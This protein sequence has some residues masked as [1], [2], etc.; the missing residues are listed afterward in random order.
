MIYR[1]T[2]TLKDGRECLLRNGTGDDARAVLDIFTLTHGQTDFLASYPDEVS[3]TL[4][5]EQDFLVGKEKSERDV[6]IVA[7]IDG[8]IV[9]S[10]GNIG[11]GKSEKTKHRASFGISVDK[12]YWGIGIGRAMT[13]ACIE[14]A[15]VA[16][17]SQLELDVVADNKAAISLYR[18]VGFVEYGRNPKAFLS[19][20]SGWQETILMRLELGDQSHQ[21]NN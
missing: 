6:Y 19:R 5:Q 4:E 11:L 1:K 15:K 18:S 2:V 21:G 3:F 17:Y 14:C 9:G 12:S 13:I 7:E 10:A 16:G 8:K 20:F